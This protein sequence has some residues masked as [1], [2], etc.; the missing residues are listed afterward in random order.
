M[1]NDRSI[2]GTIMNS[3]LINNWAGES[4]KGNRLKIKV[5]AKLKA[6]RSSITKVPSLCL[7]FVTCRVQC[8]TYV[9][10]SNTVIFKL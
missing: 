8:R 10:Y 4:G 1:A 2:L 9:Q 7:S 6:K 3:P 5:A